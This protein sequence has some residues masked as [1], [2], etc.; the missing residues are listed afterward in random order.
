VQACFLYTAATGLRDLTPAS[1]SGAARDINDA[2]QVT[3]YKTALGGY[4]AFR[5]DGGDNFV[6]LG[7]LPDFA[8]SFGFA[9]NASGQVAGNV[10]SASGNSERLFRYTDGTGLENLGGSGEHN[11]S[12]TPTRP[13]CRSS[14]RSSIRRSVGF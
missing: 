5:W 10:T 9:V 12:C 14:M 11:A 1:D 4:H 7:V 3:G 8:H 2:G 13:G 6:D